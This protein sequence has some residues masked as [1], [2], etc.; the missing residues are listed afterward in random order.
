MP[1]ETWGR[2]VI[3]EPI[4]FKDNDAIKVCDLDYNGVKYWIDYMA[5]TA[6]IGDDY[7]FKWLQKLLTPE[8]YQAVAIAIHAGSS[9]S[10][11][12]QEQIRHEATERS[13]I[14]KKS[15]SGNRKA[16]KAKQKTKLTRT[17]EAIEI[18][19][20]KNSYGNQKELVD[21]L[22]ENHGSLLA[23]SKLPMTDRR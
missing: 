20:E 15:G 4:V 11:L 21:G 2:P 14:A 16:S 23:Q 1:K 3:P 19:I 22:I 17:I 18:A 6:G 7:Y 5:Q 10:W 12:A 13:N 9:Y 8:N